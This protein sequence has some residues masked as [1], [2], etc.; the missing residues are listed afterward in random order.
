MKKFIYLIALIGLFSC[1]NKTNTSYPYNEDSLF[2]DSIEALEAN[3]K[4]EELEFSSYLIMVDDDIYVDTIRSNIK[5]SISDTKCSLRLYNFT[6][7]KWETINLIINGRK[8]VFDSSKSEEFLTYYLE[9][10]Q[11]SYINIFYNHVTNGIYVGV[12]GFYYKGKRYCCWM[13]K[14]K[15]IDED[16]IYREYESD[17]SSSEDTQ[18]EGDNIDHSVSSNMYQHIPSSTNIYSYTSTTSPNQYGGSVNINSGSIHS[19]ERITG[20]YSNYSH[21]EETDYCVEGVVVYEGT[22]DYYI[23]ETRKGCTVLERYSGVLNEGDKVRGELNRYNSKYLINRNRNTEVRVYIEDYMLSED[24]A[25]EWL[26]EHDRLKYDDQKKY[27]YN[28]DN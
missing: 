13:S 19:E 22:G 5:V 17:N 7:K 2:I 6:T 11:N 27:D 15:G 18:K 4:I 25:L 8:S 9:G 26:G 23:V 28:K 16:Y 24:D 21:Y 10:N 20:S 1:G 14:G 12:Y 3:N